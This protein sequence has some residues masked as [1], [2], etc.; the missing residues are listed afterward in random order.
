MSL[1]DMIKA[2]T[3]GARGAKFEKVGQVIG[4]IVE[5]AEIFQSRDDDGKLETW[6]DGGKKLKLRVIVQTDLDEGPDDQ[7][8]DDDGRRALFLKWWG[9]QRK[10]FLS[11]ME[12][13]GLDDLTPGCKFYA[14]FTGEG[15]KQRKSWSA[16][17]NFRYKAIPAPV[18]P[19]DS[20]FE[21]DETED[22]PSAPPAKK[23]PAK[24]APARRA[25]APEPDPEPEEEV[26]E[27]FEEEPPAPPAKKA[28]AKKA[29][30]RRA[31]PKPEPEDESLDD[32]GDPVDDTGDALAQAG[33]G[34]GDF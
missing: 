29:P 9:S 7:G 30:V 27:E 20:E 32:V 11:T 14:K 21:D 31:A 28:P 12:K 5:S 17:K 33:L 6:D 18:V 2:S 1:K 26:D 34:D 15:E 8:R 3:G 19:A 25:P 4:G 13:A 16:P 24:K 23:A 22:E 10:E